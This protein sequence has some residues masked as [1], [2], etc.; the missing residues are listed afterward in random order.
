MDISRC[1]CKIYNC[2]NNPPQPT[3]DQESQIFKRSQAH[4]P[5]GKIYA[6]LSLGHDVHKSVIAADYE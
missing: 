2:S 6:P 3:L 5:R 1:L 4:D